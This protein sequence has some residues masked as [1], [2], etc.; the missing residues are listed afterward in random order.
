MCFLQLHVRPALS[1]GCANYTKSVCL[2]VL[3]QTKNE[4]KNNNHISISASIDQEANDNTA[5]VIKIGLSLLGASQTCTLSLI[6]FTLCGTNA[7]VS[8]QQCIDISTVLCRDE[9]QRAL[10]IPGIKRIV[11]QIVKVFLHNRK[12]CVYIY[13]HF[14]L[15]KLFFHLSLIRNSR[16]VS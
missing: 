5:H 1:T 13:F 7:T 10:S 4:Q 15:T 3:N 11:F 6:P 9:W 2:Q 12:K 8:R 14:N 16:F